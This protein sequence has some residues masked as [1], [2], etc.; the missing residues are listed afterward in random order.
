MWGA[1]STGMADAAMIK[2]FNSMG[3]GVISPQVGLAAL[4][5]AMQTRSLEAQVQNLPD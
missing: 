5:Q 2:R 3:M 4:E 1:W